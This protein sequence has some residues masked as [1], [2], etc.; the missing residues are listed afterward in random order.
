[1][2]V[3]R[4]AAVWLPSLLAILLLLGV[5]SLGPGP[6]PIPA[7]EVVD[8]LIHGEGELQTVASTDG[9]VLDRRSS[10]GRVWP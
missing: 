10:W 4:R 5:V 1:M 6:V 8:L 2:N 9:Q 3:R 7:G